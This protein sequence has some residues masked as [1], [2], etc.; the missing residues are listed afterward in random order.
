M[1]P[2]ERRQKILSMIAERGVISTAELT[3]CLNVSHMTIRRDLQKLEQQNAVILVSGGVQ[4]PTRLLSEP[5]R[6]DKTR[7]ASEEKAAIAR[8]AVRHITANSCIYL[9]AGSTTLELAKQL[10]QRDPLTL[11]ASTP[12]SLSDNTL[13]VDSLTI[14]T[15]DFMIANYLMDNSHCTLIHTGGRICREN[16]SCVGE[17]TAQ[18]LN[19]LHIDQA[20]ISASSW[21]LRGISTPAEDKV[22]VK[23]S[24]AAAS[25][26]RILLCDITKYGQVATWLAL[27]IS[28]FDTIITNN[29][30]PDNAC[31]ILAKAN[32]TLLLA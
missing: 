2:V 13:A 1:I 11:N 19:N 32:I 8:I 24:I 3:A 15:N 10:C 7:M 6:Q 23:R 18:A 28:Q 22:V 29:G 4:S 21:N 16:R 27:P 25:R 12:D 30:L 14:V 9:D 31:K 26:Q 17:A 5:S 20:F